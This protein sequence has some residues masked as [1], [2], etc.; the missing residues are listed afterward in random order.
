MVDRYRKL[1]AEAQ[2]RLDPAKKKANKD[3]FRS[4]NKAIINAAKDRPCVDCGVKYPPYVM[5]F[6]HLDPSNK[7]FNIGIIGPTIS[8]VRLIAEIA[9]C[10]VV[11]ANC[12]AER[13]Y[14]QMQKRRQSRESRA[15]ADCATSSES[16]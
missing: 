6:D 5:T 2:R 12:H 16:P 15:L 13:T 14:Q 3:R 4:A 7:D 1:N 8:K 9:K 11:C 10:E